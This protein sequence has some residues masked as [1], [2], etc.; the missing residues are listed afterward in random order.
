M[1]KIR[2]HRL[3][4]KDYKRIKKRGYN[5]KLLEAVLLLLVKGELLPKEY[6]D[7]SLMGNYAGVRECHINSDWLLVYKMDDNGLTVI[8][9][10]TGSHSD[11]F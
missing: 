8:A 3:F 10:R 2:Y 5:L 6:C 4:K 11:L 9:M 7:H 1:R